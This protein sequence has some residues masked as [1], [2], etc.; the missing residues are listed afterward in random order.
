MYHALLLIWQ[1]IYLIVKPGT[2]DLFFYDY[3]YIMFWHVT[4]WIERRYL[5]FQDYILKNKM[6]EK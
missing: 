5:F 6:F 1:C 3:C 2:H 4:F